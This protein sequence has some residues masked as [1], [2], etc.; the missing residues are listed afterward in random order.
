MSFSLASLA[1]TSSFAGLATLPF[2]CFHYSTANFT[3]SGSVVVAVVDAVYAAA[4][5][6]AATEL[7]AKD[8]IL[9]RHASGQY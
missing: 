8:T 5:S 9:L 1:D 3:T 6:A 2:L 4:L 7:I